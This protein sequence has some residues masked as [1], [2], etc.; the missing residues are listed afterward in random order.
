ME[1]IKN[2]IQVIVMDALKD[3]IEEFDEAFDVSPGSRIYGGES[4]LD[5]AAV[6]SM[7]IDLEE[8]LAQEFDMDISVSD[9]RA[10]SQQRSPFRDVSS[11]VEYLFNLYQE[12]RND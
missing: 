8:R 6:V 12:M 4:P 10:M 9:E 2:R 5:S 7:I 3:A 1:Q 11:M